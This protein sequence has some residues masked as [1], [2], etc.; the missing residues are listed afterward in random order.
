LGWQELIVIGIVVLLFVRPADVPDLLYKFG[1]FVR[2][3]K[4]M[5]QSVQMDVEQTRHNINILKDEKNASNN[6]SEKPE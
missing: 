5:F 6:S 3:I 1:Q 4:E 2:Q